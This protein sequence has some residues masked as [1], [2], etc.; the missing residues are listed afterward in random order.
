[1]IVQP[2]SYSSD[3]YA[4]AVTNNTNS[5]MKGTLDTW[6]KNNLTS[7]ASYIA[8]ETFCN[9]RSV[10]GG[11]GY[12]T[13]PTTYYGAFNRL[14]NK[15]TPSLKCAQDNDKFKVSNASAKLDYPISLISADEVAMA[16]FTSNYSE[17]Y[18]W[19][20]LPSGGVNY[21]HIVTNTFGARPVINLK[22]D[23]LITKGDGTALN[24]YVVSIS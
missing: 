11:S 17:A 9:D 3:S 14:Y 13:T 1:M 22:A 24:P 19:C 21:W 18:V 10:T 20:V 23:T 12:L 5:T 6:Y 7:Y 2:I 15:R 4:D 8:D 16:Y